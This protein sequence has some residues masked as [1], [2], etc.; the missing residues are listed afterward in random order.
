[1]SG[2]DERYQIVMGLRFSDF[3][4]SCNLVESLESNYTSVTDCSQ[5]VKLG[6]N[7]NDLGQQSVRAEHAVRELALVSMLQIFI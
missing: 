1:M 5:S 4:T 6:V 2:G 7:R 3:C